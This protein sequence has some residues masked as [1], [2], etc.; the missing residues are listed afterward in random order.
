M[1]REEISRRKRDQSRRL[2][3]GRRRC[4]RAR[5]VDDGAS[6]QMVYRVG[7]KSER[8][9]DGRHASK[10]EGSTNEA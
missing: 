9:G 6:E 4:A 8:I 10:I 2:F 1:K 5:A 7:G 3:R